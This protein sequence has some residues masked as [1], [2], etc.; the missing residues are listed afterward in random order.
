MNCCEGCPGASGRS[1][2]S[3]FF[4]TMDLW[5]LREAVGLPFGLQQLP[6]CCPYSHS[7]VSPVTSPSPALPLRL[8]VSPRVRPLRKSW[9]RILREEQHR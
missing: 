8:A 6:Q 1:Q 3:F 2:P 7:E 5:V 4:A 9:V